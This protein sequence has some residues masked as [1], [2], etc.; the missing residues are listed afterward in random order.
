MEKHL[1]SFGLSQEF[2]LYR[3]ICG[4][5][6]GQKVKLVLAAAFWTVPHLIV[7]DEQTNFLDHEALGT[8]S[9]GLNKWRGAVIMIWHNCE[10]FLSFCKEE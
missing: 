4:L 10:F 1:N 5:S 6:G 2:G 9:C 3:K 7:L 8:L